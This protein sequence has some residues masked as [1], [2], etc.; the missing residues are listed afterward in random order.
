[1]KY[2]YILKYIFIIAFIS[3]RADQ[4]KYIKLR[5]YRK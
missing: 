4:N 5:K 2:I 3:K 1:M